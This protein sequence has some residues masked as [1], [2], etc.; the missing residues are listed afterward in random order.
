[1]AYSFQDLST[2]NLAASQAFSD[3]LMLVVPK[4]ELEGAS[5]VIWTIT[6]NTTDADAS[7]TGFEANPRVFDE[8]LHKA[9]KPTGTSMVW[10]VAIDFGAA[11]ITLDSVTIMTQNAA[12]NSATVSVEIADNAVFTLNLREIANSGALS[13]PAT[14]KLDPRIGFHDLQHAGVSVPQVYSSVQFLRVKLVAGINWIPTV[15]EIVVG[16]KSQFLANPLSPF[17][18]IGN[19]SRTSVFSARGGA[20][21]IYEFYRGKGSFTARFRTRNSDEFVPIEDAWQRTEQ[22]TKN[23]VVVPCPITAPNESF[24]MRIDP[25][26]ERFPV[27][28]KTQ[29]GGAWDLVEQGPPFVARE[30]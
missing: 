14:G 10:Y 9:S 22:G 8:F 1:M 16:L 13:P 11:G 6:G 26:E 19:S 24:L 20:D 5:T 2:F 12:S 29:Q 21:R 28:V 4:N 27:L 15:W 30:R 3:N 7:D 23:F 25:P 17:D 18:P